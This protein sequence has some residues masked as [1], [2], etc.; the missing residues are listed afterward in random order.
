M[1]PPGSP[2]LK[3]STFYFEIMF[4]Y[5]ATNSYILQV[6][7]AHRPLPPRSPCHGAQWVTFYAATF[8]VRIF[9]AYQFSQNGSP[10]LSKSVQFLVEIMFSYFARN[11]YILQLIWAHRP[12]PPRSPCHGAQWATCMQL[13]C[14]Q[15]YSL[16]TNSAKMEAH[17]RAN[18]YSF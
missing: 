15:E 18:Q 3:L 9:L 13:N 1:G 17:L 2:S 14:L 4:S 8:P 10:S 5:F 6:F 7:W 11:S 16:F 12:L